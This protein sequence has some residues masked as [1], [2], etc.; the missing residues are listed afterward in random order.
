M[1]PP[2][3]FHIPPKSFDL[4]AERIRMLRFVELIE[5]AITERCLV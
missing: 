1:L 2:F 5:G 4:R 3:A